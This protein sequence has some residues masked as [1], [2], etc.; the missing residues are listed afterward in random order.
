MNRVGFTH[1]F[2]WKLDLELIILVIA[3]Y[4]LAGWNLLNGRRKL[5]FDLH[6]LRVKQRTGEVCSKESWR[7]GRQLSG[8]SLTIRGGPQIMYHKTH[9]KSI[10]KIFLRI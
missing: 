3:T 7:G 5:S 6:V 9:K 1:T 8:V 2:A 4:V 10:K